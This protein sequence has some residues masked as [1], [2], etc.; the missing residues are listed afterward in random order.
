MLSKGQ[1]LIVKIFS[2]MA[3]LALVFSMLAP[4]FMEK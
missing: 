1:K 2:A 3:L 4:V